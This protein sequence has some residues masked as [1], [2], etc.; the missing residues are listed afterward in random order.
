MVFFIPRRVFKFAVLQF[1]AFSDVFLPFGLD[2]SRH[3]ERSLQQSPARKILRARDFF[4]CFLCFFAFIMAAVDAKNSSESKGLCSPN[5]R[6]FRSIS[7]QS[8][9]INVMLSGA[10]PEGVQVEDVVENPPKFELGVW[11]M[12]TMK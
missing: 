8:T 6:C 4:S 7:F 5:R 9:V 1:G 3:F 12:G 10:L 2:F 11:V